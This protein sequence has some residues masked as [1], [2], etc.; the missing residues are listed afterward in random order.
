[1]SCAPARRAEAMTSQLPRRC[2]AD[3]M[4]CPSLVVPRR[5]LRGIGRAWDGTRVGRQG[6]PQAIAQR[7]RR[8]RPP[9]MTA[10]SASSR[11]P[12]PARAFDTFFCHLFHEPQSKARL[13]LAARPDQESNRYPA[14]TRT[15]AMQVSNLALAPAERGD[16]LIGVKQN[17]NWPG[18]SS[19]QSPVTEPVL[20]G[21]LAL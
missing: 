18:A 12:R 4:A 15:P 17:C 14:G 11:R 13:S 20:I 8:P 6:W 10:A 5:L 2:S 9:S 16:L 1:V 3:G 7:R 19:V 21:V